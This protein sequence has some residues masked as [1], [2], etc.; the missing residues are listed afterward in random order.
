VGVGDG[1]GPGGT[2]L[3]GNGSSEPGIGEGEPGADAAMAKGVGWYPE[4][5]V[6]ISLA[7]N[8]DVR[9]VRLIRR[10][11][12]RQRPDVFGPATDRC[13]GND[14]ARRGG[15]LAVLAS[16]TVFRARFRGGRSQRLGQPAGGGEPS[17]SLPQQIFLPEFPEFGHVGCAGGL[18]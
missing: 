1:V 9:C 5:V 17:F 15:D 18:G 6:F 14:T 2:G 12:Q 16:H 11:E 3:G 4:T 10:S 7:P 8:S 13:V